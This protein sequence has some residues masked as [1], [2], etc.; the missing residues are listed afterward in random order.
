MEGLEL[1]TT[2]PLLLWLISD[3]HELPETEVSRA[4]SA[5]ESWVVRRTLLRATMKDVNRLFTVD[6]VGG[7]A[8]VTG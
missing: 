3:N 4:L 6:G 2:I 1:G 7:G 5:V 8:S